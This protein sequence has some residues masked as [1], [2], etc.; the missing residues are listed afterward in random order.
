MNARRR[1]K[2]AKISVLAGFLAAKLTLD[3]LAQAAGDAELRLVDPD[4]RPIG[5]ERVSN[6][7]IALFDGSSL[8]G[9]KRQSQA[10]WQV[11]DGQIFVDRGEPGLLRTTSQ[12]SNFEL[13]LEFQADPRTNSGVFV[14]T[15]PQPT[16]PAIDC[17]EI[18][19]A[20][21]DN[22]FPTASIVARKRA[23]PVDVP[24]RQFNQMMITCVDDQIRIAVNGQQVADYNDP[25]PLG[26]GYIGLQF[27]SGQVRFR[28]VWLRPLGLTVL[29]DGSNLEQWVPYPE[30]DGKFEITESGELRVTGGPGQLESKNRYGDFILQLQS[31]TNTKGQNSGVFFRCIP[32]QQSNGYE[33]QIDH[34]VE[35]NDRD[36]PA[37]FGTGGIFRRTPARRVVSN[38]QQWFAKT[39]V[40]CGP[41]ISVW[42][43]GYQVVDWSDTRPPDPNPRRGRRLEAGTIILQAHDPTT[44]V[45]FRSISAGELLPRGR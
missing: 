31:K 14:R 39:I 24:P 42:V 38:D 13:Y 40:A 18:N 16:D 41:H 4:H 28:N 1:A 26:R 8:Y 6:G 36:R 3:A 35:E 32:G 2:I 37:N 19:I 22:P 44:D 25:M 23:E 30:T 20:P 21:T 43:N 11:R 27:N 9:W 34:A 7:W 15:S 33:S 29:L 5:A 45:L 17:Y 10:N 12:F